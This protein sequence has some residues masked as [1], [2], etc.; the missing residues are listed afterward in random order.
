MQMVKFKP[1]TEPDL[2]KPSMLDAFKLGQQ[3]KLE[4]EKP[5]PLLEIL[6]EFDL[7]NQVLDGIA[8]H[9]DIV[10]CDNFIEQVTQITVRRNDRLVSCAGRAISKKQLDR[11]LLETN[12]EIELHPAVFE[13]SS[14]VPLHDKQ[15]TILHELSHVIEHHLTGNM[16]HKF[17]WMYLMYNFGIHDPKRTHKE[18]GY[19]AYAKRDETAFEK[20]MSEQ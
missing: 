2:P 16:E 6:I 8:L 11:H 17:H 15:D 14:E 20:L 12:Y 1:T 13:E 18:G 19:K 3:A 7:F 9:R 4:A 5:T 10:D